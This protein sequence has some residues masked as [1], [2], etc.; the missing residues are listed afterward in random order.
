MKKI[1]PLLILLAISFGHCLPGFAHTQVI[2]EMQSMTFGKFAMRDNNA[3]YDVVMSP[4]GVETY[5]PH[6]LPFFQGVQGVFQLTDFLPNQLLGVSIAD[7]TLVS[8]VDPLDTFDLLNFTF[9]PAAPTTN[10]AGN[11]TVNVGATLRTSGTGVL[12][13]DDTYTGS[14]TLVVI[15]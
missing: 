8:V 1:F 4:T 3:P 5:D 14:Y 2:T 10:G 9:N 11:V 6:I 15:Y 7:T 12:Y 13:T